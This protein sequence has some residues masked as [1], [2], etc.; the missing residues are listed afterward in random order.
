MC[1]S[2]TAVM[3]CWRERRSQ[4]GPG[5][6]EPFLRAPSPGYITKAGNLIVALLAEVSGW[7]SV[8]C[9]VSSHISSLERAV[10]RTR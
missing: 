4:T 2:Q 3:Y 7:G 10:A 5:T 6:F 1:V 8:E 9:H